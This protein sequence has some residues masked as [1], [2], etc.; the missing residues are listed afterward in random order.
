M[1]NGE[2]LSILRLTRLEKAN[3]VFLQ[4]TIQVIAKVI[5]S[6]KHLDLRGA[7]H[8]QLLLKAR[9]VTGA[10][11]IPDTELCLSLDQHCKPPCTHNC[12]QVNSTG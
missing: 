11:Q 7:A 8:M 12:V 10:H 4:I 2:F 3:M 9:A 5:T 6:D 1:K